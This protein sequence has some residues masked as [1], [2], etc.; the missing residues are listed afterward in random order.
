M[1]FD[2]AAR[3][4]AMRATQQLLR[5]IDIP[6]VSV[7]IAADDVAGREP[8]VV[9]AEH[10]VDEGVVRESGV[11]G[12]ELGDQEAGFIDSTAVRMTSSVAHERA[13]FEVVGD[14]RQLVA[15]RQ[16]PAERAHLAGDVGEHEVALG[17]GVKLANLER[18]EALDQRTPE[19]ATHARAG[20][21][22]QRVVA[23]RGRARGVDERTAH[24]AGIEQHG[25]TAAAH[26][27]PELDWIEPA[28]ERQASAS[29]QRPADGHHHAGRMV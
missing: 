14:D 4:P 13:G 11:C 17:R 20:Q 19:I 12:T 3:D 7:G 25:R 9:L 5:A 23:L 27:R 10:V 1:I 26:L 22:A 28:C 29:D 2:L 16:R 15:A 24:L 8:P 21:H 6:E 18:A